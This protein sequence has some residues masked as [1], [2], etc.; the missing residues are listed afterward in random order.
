MTAVDESRCLRNHPRRSKWVVALLFIVCVFVFVPG[1]PDVASAQLGSEIALGCPCSYHVQGNSITFSVEK[2]RNRRTSR[3]GTLM[4]EVWATQ[5]PYTGVGIRGYLLAEVRLGELNGNHY[6]SYLS[7]SRSLMR[8]PPPGTYYISIIL[9]EY[10]GNG[11]DAVK[12]FT[13][14]RQT[15]TFGGS[16][17][18]VELGCPCSYRIRENYI[19]F[20]TARVQNKRTS[21]TGALRLQVWATYAPYAG[22]EITGYL[23][24]EA[25]VGTLNGNSYFSYPS[26]TEVLRSPPA[27]TYYISLLLTE[28]QRS[29]SDAVRD[30]RAFNKTRTF[31]GVASAGVI[32]GALDIPAGYVL[33]GDTANPDDPVAENNKRAQ[34]VPVPS[35]ILGFAA[36]TPQIA[37][38]FDFY[39]VTLQGSIGMSLAIAEPNAA[40]LD[41]YLLEQT[42]SELTV[43]QGSVGTGHYETIQTY[44]W[45]RGE[46]LI[47]VK[48]Q[49]GKS[50]YVLSLGI[51]GAAAVADNAG[52]LSLDAEF[53]PDELVVKF[54]ENL[55]SAQYQD[56]VAFTTGAFGLAHVAGSQSDAILMRLED[57]S[58]A[59][60]STQPESRYIGPLHYETPEQATKAH[61]VD[62]IK[63]LRRDP[64]VSYAEPNYIS[65]TMATPNDDFYENQWHYDQINLP[66]AWD[67]TKGD[68]SVVI[69]VID[70]GVRPHPDLV[71]RILR[72]RSGRWVGYDFIENDSNPI[73]PGNPNRRT[74]SSGF[75][76]THVAGTIGAETNNG[77]GV[78]GVTWRGKLMPLRVIA[79][80]RGSSYA[81]TQAIRYAAGLSNDSGTRPPVRADVLNLSL[82]VSN[83]I[84]DTTI[85]CVR[86][87]LPLSENRRRTLEAA[88]DAGVAVVISAGNDDCHVPAAMSKVDGVI[89][90][91]AVDLNA[92]KAWYSNYG[93]AIDVAAPGGD[94]KVDRDGNGFP[95]GVYSTVGDDSGPGSGVKADYQGKQG[96]SMAAPHMAGVVALMLSVNPDLTPDDINMLLAGTHPHPRAG[97]ITR[98]LG[99][100]GR[101]DIYGH[102]LIDA[103]KA[104]R[105]AQAIAR[106]GGGPSPQPGDGPV[107]SVFPQSLNFGTER[108]ELELELRNTGTGDLRVTSI[109]PHASWLAVDG[110]RSGFVTVRVSRAG[111][112]ENSYLG[113]ISI[114]SNG[115]NETIPISMQVQ[116]GRSRGA[117]GTVYVLVLDA[118]DTSQVI[119][120]TTG[121]AAGSY[122]YRTPK[123]P[124]GSYL[125]VAGTDRDNDAYICDTGEACGIYPLQD[126][127]SEIKVDGDRGGINFLVSVNLLATEASPQG[128]DP[129]ELP[130]EGFSR[131]EPEGFRR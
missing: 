39:S 44:P 76:G 12:D 30:F 103:Q 98:D 75:H 127:P 109:R 90:V 82:G 23:L 25:W 16:G 29:G 33:D 31:G 68:D 24:A 58:A 7:Y 104:V 26:Y 14:F 54:E 74:K 83:R 50:N 21:R 130:S 122:V 125:V 100:P 115:G 93:R 119:A 15:V 63:L 105:V 70:T 17:G 9:T 20:S 36:D 114:N 129:D 8:V 95:D 32:S 106:A 47:A 79:G 72:D 128:V 28:Y 41:L 89:N 43:I 66:A 10:Q 37:D 65:H 126:D 42:G 34:R 49:H 62:M 107:L 59:P 78:A 46:Y 35:T 67:I 84:E 27:G 113:L 97:P 102:G 6:F 2:V 111:L 64:T 120:R 18:R 101:D 40:D 19:T 69:A 81:V 73:D 53:V 112:V 110:S 61:V 48:A 92:R 51:T 57:T 124:G 71:N 38:E 123:V 117:V 108:T 87:D 55:D 3:S 13:A 118:D 11:R 121:N 77:R 86:S 91:S 99:A 52:I 45:L 60:L 116:T 1:M 96:T 88:L 4:L 94:T 85:T 56:M 131:L 5:R 80:R 22:I